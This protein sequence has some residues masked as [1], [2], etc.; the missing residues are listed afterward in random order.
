MAK[1]RVTILGG[2][3]SG[4]V[5]ALNLTAPENRGRYDVTVYQHGW[6]LGGKCA[7]GRD[8]SEGARIQEHGLHVFM[9]QYDNAFHMVQQLYK[10][11]AHPPFAT[12]EEAFTQQPT[13]ALME[14]V[15]DE[16]IPWDINVPVFPGTPG[17]GEP[18]SIW[19]RMIQG[20]EWIEHQMF[21]EHIEIFR[22]PG[23][24]IPGKGDN[25]LSR[26]INGI[27]SALGLLALSVGFE[28]VRLAMR[29][30]RE[31]PENPNDHTHDHHLHLAGILQ[32]LKEW[33]E[34]AITHL[35][36]ENNTLRRLWIM[37]DLMLSNGIGAL[38]DGLL[39]DPDDNLE[40]VNAL[41]YKEWLRSHGCTDIAVESA[42]IRGLYDLIFGYEAGDW[43]SDGN[44]E[45]GTM[46]L[47]LMN[48]MRYR[49][50][51]IW[52]FNTATGDLVIAPLYEVL[53]ARGV[54]FEFFARVDELTPSAS[55]NW[56]S[57]VKVGRQVNMK[58]GDYNPLVTMASGERVW[59]DR[60]L[61][62][63][64]KEGKALEKS[65][66]NL[67]SHWTGWK[68]KA[69]PL[70]LQMGRDYDWLVLAIPP[71][72]HPTICKKLM[73]QNPAWDAMV[74]NVATVVTQ[75]L[76]VW[77]PNAQKEMGWDYSTLLG[78]YDATPLNTWCDISEILPSENWPS[79]SK[80]KSELIA[81]GPM[82]CAQFPPPKSDKGFPVQSYAE[83]KQYAE[84]FLNND[85]W[86][87]WPKAFSKGKAGPI[88]SIYHRANIDPS[89][90][91]TL[92]VKGSS[93]YRFKTN[94]SGY[95]N[96]FLTGDWI[97]NGQNQ[98][99]FE[100]TTISGKLCSK[101]IS[102]YPETVFRIDADK[103]M[104][105]GPMM[106]KPPVNAKY[107]EH[108]GIV[109]FPGPIMLKDTTM[110]AFLLEADRGLL[111]DYCRKVF[112]DTSGGAV[113]VLPLASHMM[114]TI[115]D[116]KHGSYIDLP[117]RGW[118]PERE[119][120]FWIPVVRVEEKNGRTVA[121]H[122]NLM[123]PYLVLNNPGAI[124]AGREVFGYWKQRGNLQLPSETG[125]GFNVDL[126]SS[127]TFGVDVEETMNRFVTLTALGEKQS[128]KLAKVKTFKDAV[129]AIHAHLKPEITK[130]HTTLKFDVETL[131][132]L[133]TGHVP[134]LF[135][136]QFRDISDGNNAC[137]QAITESMGHVAKF[138]SLPHFVEYD[139]VIEALASSP[140]CT[141]FGINPRQ[142]VLGAE[143][144]IDLKINP[145]TTLWQA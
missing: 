59:P 89:E 64:I 128:A 142:K 58:S 104:A 32:K 29:V 6:R 82:P 144:D 78:A 27:L 77:M 30:I 137:Y 10:E 22:K 54:K 83:T 62:D 36:D 117:E 84:D 143:I 19:E 105:T 121:T 124:A 12:W 129:K 92:T 71:G 145:G 38:R 53:K 57:E 69:K 108:G 20:L 49:G 133:M 101:A 94:G 100:A 131:A 55:G 56:I 80:V 76:Q 115:V 43:K 127:P 47:S 103:Q 45:A 126:F 52:K 110:W 73:A 120:A 34:K 135:L 67:E 65:G 93:K 70:T 9:G 102:G 113:Q 21:H 132:E 85:G 136:K 16:W 86:R 81:C 60:P 14:H 114:M 96:L 72:A 40:R 3:L 25:W 35:L 109:T 116:I 46:F 141:D 31:L 134:Q 74:N 39:L 107:V 28:M 79:N 26:L 88:E 63:Q 68:D 140:V 119:L 90:R 125:G 61:Y 5:T 130:W 97:D 48:T 51:I 4:L 111:E 37:F 91:Y 41:D 75:N 2:G 138:R 123:M 106:S 7:T 17:E 66:E 139:M 18:P 95:S 15:G 24:H 118:S 50:S 98:G 99:S 112:T 1:E 87:F 42:I 11:A 8:F 23:G 13:V 44:T 122:F 33:I